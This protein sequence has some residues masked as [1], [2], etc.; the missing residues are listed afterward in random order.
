MKI[1][2]TTE[3]SFEG[4]FRRIRERKLPFNATVEE[5]VRTILADVR[6]RGDDALF[7]YTERFDGTRLSK[8]SVEIPAEVLDRALREID[9]DV[10]EVLQVAAERIERFHENQVIPSWRMEEDGAVMGQETIPLGRVGVYAPGGLAAYPSTVLMGAIPARVAG[11]RE[12]VLAT[13]AKNGI[14][15]PVL[16]A[17]A[18]LAGVTRVFRIGGAQAVAALAYGTESVPAV[19]KIVGPG[20]IYVATAKKLVFGDVGIDMIAG[21]SEILVLSDGTGDPAVIAADLLSQAEHDGLASALFLTPDPGL[22]RRVA[23]EVDRQL[24]DLSRGE[25]ARQSIERF[26]R[27]IVTRDLEEALFL[28]NRFAPEHLELMVRN[29]GE[30]LP[31]VTGAGAIFLGENTPEALGDYLAGPNHILPTGGTARFASPLGVY[32]FV[33]RMSVLDFSPQALRRH[34]ETVIR[35]AGMEGLEAHGRA[36]SLRL[37]GKKS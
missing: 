17:A 18:R 10:R 20:N 31:R 16:L 3:A 2:E 37:R 15:Q 34:G 26:G 24:K 12:I 9:E 7:A 5:T 29:P 21:P 19:D 11:V 27:V 28:A 22:A 35:F 13:P 32:D 36:V 33:K 8:D 6:E 1:I 14:V 30:I 4:E 25:I 23:G